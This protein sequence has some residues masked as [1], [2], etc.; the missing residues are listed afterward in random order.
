MVRRWLDTWT[1][2]GLIVTGMARQGYRLHLTN[3]E[4]GI[5]RA[6]GEYW[7]FASSSSRRRRFPVD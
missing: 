3:I 4:P 7:T 6:I 5:W 1:G 2:L